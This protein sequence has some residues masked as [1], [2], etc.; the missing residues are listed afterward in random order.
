MWSVF[1]K[2]NV[3]EGQLIELLVEVRVFGAEQ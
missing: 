3:D 1:G 2:I